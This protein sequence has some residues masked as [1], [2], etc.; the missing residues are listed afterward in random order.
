MSSTCGC[1][2]SGLL[3]MSSTCGCDASGLLT[4]S[5][6]CGCDTSGLLTMSSTCGCDASGLLTMSST[7][8]CDASGLVTM[9][10][11]CGCAV[12]ESKAAVC[13]SAVKTEVVADPVGLCPVVLARQPVIFTAGGAGVGLLVA[14]A[15]Q[16]LTPSPTVQVKQPFSP[17][18]ST[19]LHK[20][21]CTHSHKHLRIYTHTHTHTH[22]YMDT[23]VSIHTLYNTR[24][25][26]PLSLCLPVLTL[27]FPGAVPL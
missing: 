27:M 20:Y 12:K 14:L 13:C 25:T 21:A 11:T 10:S 19:C 8:G 2:A 4:M 22:I 6:T 16:F 18:A 17:S 23:H 26:H 15:D 24:Y 7:C 9:S 3:T 5:S 1:D